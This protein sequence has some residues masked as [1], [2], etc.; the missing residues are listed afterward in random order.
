[1]YDIAFLK[2]PTPFRKLVYFYRGGQLR[3]AMAELLGDMAERSGLPLLRHQPANFG[4][5]LSGG[6]FD[7]WHLSD[8]GEET[9]PVIDAALR[10]LLAYDGT[11]VILFIPAANAAAYADA[12]WRQ[13]GNVLVIEE[14][15]ANAE[16]LDAIAA[17][18]LKVTDLAPPEQLSSDPQLRAYL[19]ARL[20]PHYTVGDVFE[21]IEDYV[22]TRF[23]QPPLAIEEPRVAAGSLRRAIRAFVL[24]GGGSGEWTLANDALLSG[25]DEKLVLGALSSATV[26]MLRPFFRN[27]ETGS[28]ATAEAFVLWACALLANQL[29]MAVLLGGYAPSWRTRP[30]CRTFVVTQ[31]CR[32]FRRAR[33]EAPHRD[34]LIGQAREALSRL[35]IIA[36]S[37]NVASARLG[38]AIAAVVQGREDLPVWCRAL[39]EELR[40]ETVSPLRLALDFQGSLRA[41][42][43]SQPATKQLMRRV[44]AGHHNTPTLFH[45]LRPEG[46]GRLVGAWVKALLC[47]Q[48]L[49]GDCC[50]ACTSCRDLRCGGS[51]AYAIGHMEVSASDP[52]SDEA[53]MWSADRQLQEVRR[54][55]HN[56]GLW[57][58]RRVVVLQGVDKVR[59]EALDRVLKSIEDAPT[60]VSFI[61]LAE[62]LGH[63]PAAIKSRS[64]AVAMKAPARAPTGDIG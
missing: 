51:A 55:V 8:V 61:F 63:V 54:L 32:D 9:R 15:P 35:P 6:F 24:S 48:P 25:D 11:H 57:P 34:W 29:G 18:G 40:A 3:K 50:D 37:D 23:N 14:P 58:G 59:K 60:E 39:K 21:D 12:P 33:H 45:G 1:M 31:L 20:H 22:L 26:A 28:D 53:E 5:A 10:A 46:V 49:D 16:T 42:T 41:V 38:R 64:F 62:R 4:V 2:S 56:Q 52:D 13:M 7:G 36:S 17:F 44:D 47:E 27:A 43:H 30:D 19:L